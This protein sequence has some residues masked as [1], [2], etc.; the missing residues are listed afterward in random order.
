MRTGSIDQLVYFES[1]N[2]TNSSGENT[3]T[4]SDV[5]GTS[6]AT[7]DYAMIFSAKG[8]EALE[9]AK[10][11]SR[12]VLRVKLRYRSDVLTSWRMKWFDQYYEIKHVD[13][14]LHRKG[15]LWLTVELLGAS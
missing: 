6:P 5:S 4:W 9:S 11:N 10:T 3:I 13:R 14:S 15:E 7:P 8:N 12:E 2:E 1:P